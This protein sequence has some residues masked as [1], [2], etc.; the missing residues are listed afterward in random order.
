MRCANEPSAA[1][2]SWRVGSPLSWRAIGRTVQPAPRSEAVSVHAADGGK[3][4]QRDPQAADRWQHALEHSPPGGQAGGVAHDGGAGVEQA[5]AA[6]APVGA[7]HELQRSELRAEGCRHHRAV[8]EPACA[9]GGVLRGREDGD[10]SPRSQ[11][12]G[13]AA[14]AG[15][16][17]T[18]R[19][20]VL[21]ARHAGAV[22]GV[23]YEDRRSDR[24]DRG[25]A[26]LGAV[27][28]VSHRHRGASADWA[29]DSR[30]RRQPVGAARRFFRL[31]FTPT[32]SSNQVERGLHLARRSRAEFSSVARAS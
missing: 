3:D 7:L 27:R 32:Y 9:R 28:S 25:A 19:V 13:A 17:R 14:V 12:S 31:H 29:G 30:D 10:S 8:P 24:Q 16:S 18:A 4:P 21:P 15:T 22:R 5:S 1:A 2:A 6:A 26:H 11:R 23:Q 20:R